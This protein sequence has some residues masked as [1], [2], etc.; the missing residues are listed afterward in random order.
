MTLHQNKRLENNETQETSWSRHSKN[1][2]NKQTKKPQIF[3]LK[4]LKTDREIIS[5]VYKEQKNL[6]TI[7]QKGLHMWFNNIQLIDRYN[8]QL[9]NQHQHN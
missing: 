5:K 7:V 1:L 3:Q 6:E 9:I 2:K 4:L 8:V